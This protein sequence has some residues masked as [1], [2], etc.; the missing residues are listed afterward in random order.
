MNRRLVILQT[1]IF[2]VVAVVV[3]AYSLYNL[4]GVRVIDLPYPVTVQLNSGGGVFAGSEV[5][6]RG[7][8]I[9][10]V[11]AVDLG[12]DGVTAHLEIDHGRRVPSDATA[13]V[14]RLSIV[15]EQYLDFYSSR[16][17][18][19]YLASGSV[20][21]VTR[22][23]VP[24]QTSVVLADFNR[25]VDSLDPAKLGIVTKE[26][27]AAFSG[28]EADLSTILDSGSTL[29]AE[30]Q[31]AAPSLQHILSNSDVLLGTAA[32]HEGDFAQFSV[33][34][35]QITATLQQSTPDITKLM[36]AGLDAAQ[37]ANQVIVQYGP[38]F[39]LLTADLSTFS[40]LQAPRVG[41][42]QAL[43]GAIVDFEVKVPQVIR[44]GRLQAIALFDYNQPA[45]SYVNQLTSPLSEIKSPLQAVSCAHPAAG[46]LQ[47]GAQNAPR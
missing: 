3:I 14:T 44:D 37:V 40:H 23:A 30:M 21:P 10:K 38:T 13:T 31:A 2:A 42:W 43:L 33:A 11:A 36:G 35:R 28:S 39:T 47:R 46:T 27:A 1:T 32:A 34:A 7:V 41:A 45:C 4:I 16:N 17:D 12:K 26:L 22:T 5:T 20:V 24:P 25:L 9:G 18:G 19:P 6:Y 29:L 8:R 15:G